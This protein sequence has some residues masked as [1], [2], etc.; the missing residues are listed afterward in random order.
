MKAVKPIV[1]RRSKHGGSSTCSWRSRTVM[2]SKRN[3]RQAASRPQLQMQHLSR[4]DRFQPR[5][6][7]AHEDRAGVDEAQVRSDGVLGESRPSRDSSVTD[8]P[9]GFDNLTNGFLEQGPPYEALNEDTV[10]ALRSFNDNRFIFEEV[11]TV[12]DGL[13]RRTTRRA[14]ANAIRTSSLVAPVRWR[15]FARACGKGPVFRVARRYPDPFTRDPPGTGLSMYGSW[16]PFEHCAS[17]PTHSAMASSK[18]LPM[19]R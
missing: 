6:A 17:Q 11:E 16:R 3:A 9:T 2:G 10:V 12:A 18:R 14:A 5:G 8:A 1:R 13:G 19:Q 15:S 4:P 7:L